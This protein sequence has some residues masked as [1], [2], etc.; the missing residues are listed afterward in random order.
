MLRNVKTEKLLKRPRVAVSRSSKGI[1]AQI[2]DDLKQVT[3]VAASHQQ[4]KSK[5]KMTK[6][7]Q[8]KAVGLLLA[9]KAK[10]KKISQVRF[11][12]RSFR[13][14]GRVKALAESLREGG[15]DF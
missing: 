1:S 2:I 8:A 11:D 9:Q 15:L 12:R 13:Y 6:V 10:A 14:H 3:L 4:L 5:Q 7:E